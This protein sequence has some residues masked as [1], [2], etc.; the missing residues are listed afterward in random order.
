MSFQNGSLADLRSVIMYLQWNSLEGKM[1]RK[2]I[3]EQKKQQSALSSSSLSSQGLEEVFR[4][5]QN[6]RTTKHKTDFI[7]YGTTAGFHPNVLIPS[8]Q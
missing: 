2:M 7:D 5:T 3:L 1:Q 6:K 4:S 8:Q